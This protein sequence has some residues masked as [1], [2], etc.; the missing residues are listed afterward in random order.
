MQNANSGKKSTGRLLK[1]AIGVISIIVIVVL[2]A[3]VF[4]KQ[5]FTFVATRI[6]QQRILSQTH[7]KADGLYA[8][9]AGTGAPFSD[10]NRVGPCIVVEAGNNLYIIDAGPGS[11]RN[12]GLMGFNIGKVEAILL[13]H[14]HSDHIADLGEMM[15]QR[16]AAGSNTKPVDVIGPEGVETVVAGFNNAYSLDAVYRV[17]FHGAATV[18][19][20]G[21]GW[22]GQAVCLIL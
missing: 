12:I 1:A 7:K 13:T 16:W 19:P 22:Q 2:T 11:A 5:I 8:G 21:A 15:L 6:I 4:Q 17:A 20:S 10:I 18:P 14:F 3:A 9:L